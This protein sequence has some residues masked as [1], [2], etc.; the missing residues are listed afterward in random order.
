MGRL[1]PARTAEHRAH[2]QSSI[3]LHTPFSSAS[4]QPCWPALPSTPYV[5]HPHLCHQNKQNVPQRAIFTHTCSALCSS[6]TGL[7]PAHHHSPAHSSLVQQTPQ[8][9]LVSHQVLSVAR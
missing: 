7:W 3:L 5:L 6:Q 8:Q 9:P 2:A 1:L 4:K